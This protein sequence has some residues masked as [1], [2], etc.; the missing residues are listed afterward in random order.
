MTKKG[1]KNPDPKTPKKKPSKTLATRALTK[2]ELEVLKHLIMGKSNTKIGESLNI[3][4]HTVKAHVCTILRKMDV[5]D[6]VQIAVK[7]IRE[8]LVK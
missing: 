7:A 5:T 4:A 1:Q 6:R 3:S 8:G 2:R